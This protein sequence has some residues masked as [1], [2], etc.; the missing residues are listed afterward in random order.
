MG[1]TGE[2]ASGLTQARLK[3]LLSYD[4][5]TGEFH[6]RVSVRRWRAGER[7]GCY[8]PTNGYVL[9]RVDGRL[10]KGHPARL[11]LHDQ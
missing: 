11:V 5:I 7:A 3:E 1:T 6:R 2:M 10:Y 9:I 8:D 4:P